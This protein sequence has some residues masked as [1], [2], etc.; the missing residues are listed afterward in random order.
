MVL[1]ILKLRIGVWLVGYFG[2]NKI[3]R[4]FYLRWL[5]CWQI[6]ALLPTDS[7]I[8]LCVLFF[9]LVNTLFYLLHFLDV[10]F[11][12]F[13]S[14]EILLDWLHCVSSSDAS[15]LMKIPSLS[16]IWKFILCI[17]LKALLLD[18][19]FGPEVI[20][21]HRSRFGPFKR[22]FFLR[23][24][25]EYF[26]IRGI[27]ENLLIFS[28]KLILPLLLFLL[29]NSNCLAPTHLNSP[30]LVSRRILQ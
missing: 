5:Y 17:L 25:L 22:F 4:L 23:W 18:R 8:I 7:L 14:L 1:F 27:V 11:L 13:L 16:I 20:S 24:L 3:R 2:R 21:S 26:R 6:F 30:D 12:R 29:P 28:I 10:S 19:F 15:I 9:R